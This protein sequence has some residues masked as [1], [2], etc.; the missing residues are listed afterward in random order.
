MMLGLF[1]SCSMNRESN[2]AFMTADR[3]TISGAPVSAK[4]LVADYAPADYASSSAAVANTSDTSRR[5]IRTAELR[6]KTKDAIRGTYAIEDII[7]KH[8]GFVANTELQSTVNSVAR[9]RVSRDSTLITTFYTISNSMQL[10]VPYKKLDSSLKEIALL[11]EFMDYRRVSA[12][13]VQ[14]SILRNN[15]ERRRAI[16]Q[17]KRLAD[18]VDEKG[19]KLSHIADAEDR[20]ALRQEQADGAL[21]ANL[22]LKDQI[23]Y[24]AI[25]VYMWQERTSKRE[26]AA[27]EENIGEYRPGFGVRVGDALRT[28]WHGFVSVIVFLS[29]FW[30]L[31]L[32]AV[33]VYTGIRM[34]RRRKNKQHNGL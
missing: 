30:V 2:E 1:V 29:H 17:E 25:T 32:L 9:T 20:I 18:A 15:L 14:L 16:R 22:E 4:E 27:N 34:Y 21:L 19:Q 26:M 31:W 10:R 33:G 5:F 11:A 8:G 3:A 13:D 7:L 23:E 12:T 6:F 28:G 24:S